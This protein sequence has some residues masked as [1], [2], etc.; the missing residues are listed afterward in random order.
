MPNVNLKV[1]KLT[2]KH[3]IFD[4]LE[5]LEHLKGQES[6]FPIVNR[7]DCRFFPSNAIFLLQF[8]TARWRDGEEDHFL[9]QPPPSEKVFRK[10][11]FFFFV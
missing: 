1:S 10:V 4:K 6:Y 7:F 5:K 9:F 3:Y 11:I 8:L 2:S